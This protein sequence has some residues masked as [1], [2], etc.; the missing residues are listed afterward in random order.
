MLYVILPMFFPHIMAVGSCSF[1]QCLICAK[2]K[3]KLIVM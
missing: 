1:D 3:C 2:K